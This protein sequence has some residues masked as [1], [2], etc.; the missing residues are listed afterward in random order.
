ML[1][2]QSFLEEVAASQEKVL[3]TAS[4]AQQQQLQQQHEMQMQQQQ[5]EA[6]ILELQAQV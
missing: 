2:L 6:V 1:G 5:Y 3:E 4:I